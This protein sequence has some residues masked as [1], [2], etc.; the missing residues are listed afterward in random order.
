[1]PTMT[2]KTLQD[3]LR[4]DTDLY[5]ERLLPHPRE[6]VYGRSRTP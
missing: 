1:M 3:A 4:G 6:H 2:E 5:T